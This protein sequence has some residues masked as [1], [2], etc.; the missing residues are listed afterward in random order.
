MSNNDGKI[1]FDAIVVGA[2]LAGSAAAIVMARAGLN[3]ALI[4]RGQKAGAKNYFGGAIYT[5]AIGEVLPDYMDRRPPFERPVTEAGF[6]MLSKDG[7]LTRLTVQGGKLASQPADAYMTSRALFDAWWAEQA[8]QAGALLIPKTTVLDV[9]RDGSGQVIGVTTDRAQ[10]DVYAP[11]VIVCEGVNNLLTQKL[12]LID[13]DLE[14]T[15]IALAFKQVIA[16][17]MDTI[18][19]RFGLSDDQQGIAASVLGDVSLGLPGMGFVYT[20]K[21]SISV[22]LGMML[23]AVIEYRLKPYE[24]LQRYL[25]HPAIAPLVKGGQLLEY[26]AHLI[27]EGGYRDMPRLYTGGAMVAGDAASMVNALHWEGTNMAIIAG[28]VAAETAIEAHK[29]GDFS[30]ATLAQ[31]EEC[32]KERFILQDMKQYR[33]F[34]RFLETHPAFMDTYPSFINEALEQF[35]SA[36]GQPKKQLFKNIMGSLTS[37]RQFLK[38]VGDLLSMGRAVMGW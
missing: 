24:V 21:T 19:A 26:G 35:F 23:D 30:S 20:N 6:W 8:Q 29:R 11:V 1:R 18:H 36:Y 33:N 32:L 27:P 2:G 16:L 25:R 17:P 28:K 14:P 12:G 13:H 10:G 9:I 15:H 4:E 38:A 34:A 7:A 31:Y 3:V 22:G 5:H 37:R